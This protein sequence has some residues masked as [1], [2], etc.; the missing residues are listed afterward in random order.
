[1]TK[2]ILLA[3]TLCLVAPIGCGAPPAT[4]ATAVTQSD[5]SAPWLC[6]PSTYDPLLLSNGGWP[7]VGWC[8]WQPSSTAGT[9]PPS[10][11]KCDTDPVYPKGTPPSGSVDVFSGV[12]LTGG[13]AR[14]AGGVGQNVLWDFAH[15][16]VN[17]WDSFKP[18]SGDKPAVSTWIHSVAIGNRRTSF[19]VW[20]DGSANPNSCNAGTCQGWFVDPLNGGGG[21]QVMSWSSV[22][23]PANFTPAMFSIGNVQ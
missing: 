4:E 1:M 9:L 3:L 23:L 13:C 6:A 2:R 11:S 12:N 18:A 22:G 8:Q 19:T 20:N 5:L 14:V 7:T 21:V 17:G 10:V 15:V 16:V